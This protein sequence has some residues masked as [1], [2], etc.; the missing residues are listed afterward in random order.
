MPLSGATPFTF[1]MTGVSDTADSTSAFAGAMSKLTNLVPARDTKN[2]WVCRPAAVQITAYPNVTTPGPNTAKLVVGDI[3]YGLVGDKALGVDIPYAYNLLTNVFLP[4]QGINTPNANTPVSPAATGAWTPPTMDVVGTRIVVTHPGF[5][6]SG[7]KFG[8]FDVS[9]FTSASINVATLLGSVTINPAS[10]VLLAGWQVGMFING[11]NIPTNATII[12]IAAG[13]LSVVISN[14]A[15]GTAGA[16]LATVIGGTAASPLWNAGDT[17][18]NPLASTPAYV[19]QMNGRAFFAV[20]AGVVLSDSLQ[21]TQV[22]NASQV[23]TFANGIPVT[24]LGTLA[25]SAPITGGVVQSLFVFQG[26]AVIQQITG[27]PATN[28]LAKNA[29]VANTGTRAPSSVIST[30]NGLVFVSPEG[31]RVIG[32]DAKVSDPIGYQGDGVAQ[33]FVNAVEPSRICAAA[34]ANVLRISTQNGG[35]AG[36]PYEEYWLD[37]ERKTWS[38]PHTFPASIIQPWRSTFVMQPA[39]ATVGSSY[40]S[41]PSPTAISAFNEGGT[42]MAF[43]ARTS[44][45]PDNQAMAMNSIVESTLMCS[46][47]I[48]SQLAIVFS[49]DTDSVLDQIYL[50]P[51]PNATTW[52]VFTWGSAAWQRAITS[53]IQ[54]RLPWSQPLVFKQA[55]AQVY[56]QSAASVKIGSLCLRYKPLGY[57]VGP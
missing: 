24:A 2:A 23:L 20:G 47:A 51:A 13:G 49:D 42:P 52:G 34:N 36:S 9:S 18:G 53:F 41:D 7:Q 40:R 26:E 27:D 44:L 17:S 50:G 56:G 43:Y 1:Q 31:M 30:N 6:G 5:N 32:F 39:G 33:P 28:N 37:L 21:A 3:E 55:F 10:N 54:R 15:T 14:P 22:T 19:R 57:T 29:I 46:L 11:P 35:A 45:L 48:G 12:S 38:G 25:L 8:W 16:S 4:V